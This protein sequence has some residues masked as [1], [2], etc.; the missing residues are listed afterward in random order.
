MGDQMNHMC[1]KIQKIVEQKVA[2]EIPMQMQDFEKDFKRQVEA[3]LRFKAADIFKNLQAVFNLR[4]KFCLT[5]LGYDTASLDLGPFLETEAMYEPESISFSKEPLKMYN[6]KEYKAIQNDVD[7]LEKSILSQKSLNTGRGFR[8][9]SPGSHHCDHTSGVHRHEIKNELLDYLGQEVRSTTEYLLDHSNK[10]VGELT[11]EE[12]SIL[13]KKIIAEVTDNME[14]LEDELKHKFEEIITHKMNKVAEV[15]GGVSPN[16]F[17]GIDRVRSADRHHGSDHNQK[18]SYVG[19]LP[20]SESRVL[21]GENDSAGHDNKEDKYASDYDKSLMRESL[22]SE[23]RTSE[24]KSAN[25]RGQDVS[26]AKDR[27]QKIKNSLNFMDDEDAEPRHDHHMYGKEAF[28]I[29]L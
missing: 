24:V 8:P 13:Y 10:K 7:R 11:R 25:S 20:I 18:G 5:R 1:Q 26:V 16:E 23:K 14:A 28:F 22:Y 21:K 6:E 19:R 3:I 29:S 12:S 27:I 15:L 9:E 17:S 2:L 4:L